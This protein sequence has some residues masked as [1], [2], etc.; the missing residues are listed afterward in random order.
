[1][2]L[3]FWE[4]CWGSCAWL[5]SRPVFKVRRFCYGKEE[6]CFTAQ[7]NQTCVPDKW[8]LITCLSTKLLDCVYK[9]QLGLIGICNPGLEMK[10]TLFFWFPHHRY[11]WVSCPASSA[12][13]FSWLLSA[14]FCPYYT[15][16]K[17]PPVSNVCTHATREDHASQL[18]ATLC[19]PSPVK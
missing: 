15:F 3:R 14:F 9:S 5:L 18:I 13:F 1:M 19:L 16:G 12:E 2:M 17:S 4:N 6:N 8:S 11:W 10:P 7:N